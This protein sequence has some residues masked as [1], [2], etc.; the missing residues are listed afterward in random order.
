M[1]RECQFADDVALL[2][3][4]EKMELAISTYIEVA[5]SFGLTVSLQKTI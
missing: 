3:T 4:S 5:S 1:M 2:A